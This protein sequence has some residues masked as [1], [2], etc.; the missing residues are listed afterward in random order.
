M[1]LMHC[2]H[3]LVLPCSCLF[4]GVNASKENRLWNVLWKTVTSQIVCVTVQCSFNPRY[5]VSFMS[6][7]LQWHSSIDAE[8]RILDQ[9]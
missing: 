5:Y 1:S 6:L 3:K 7:L 8:N 9:F 2:T 4:K